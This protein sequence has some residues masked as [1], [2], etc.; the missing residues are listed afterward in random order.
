MDWYFEAFKCHEEPK[1]AFLQHK[2]LRLIEANKG[3]RKEKKKAFKASGS[4]SLASLSQA[5][6]L[7]PSP[8]FLSTLTLTPLYPQFPHTHSLAKLSL[9]SETLPILF[10]SALVRPVPLKLSLLRI[11]SLNP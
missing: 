1:I 2:I 11:Q 8:S 5:L 3:L 4:S 6:P 7:A 9:F 10:F